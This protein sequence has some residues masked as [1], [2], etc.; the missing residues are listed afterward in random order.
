MP[1]AIARIMKPCFKMLDKPGPVFI[2]WAIVL[3][4][5]NVD[6]IKQDAAAIF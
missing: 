6:G 1:L 3:N 5:S 4:S 2:V